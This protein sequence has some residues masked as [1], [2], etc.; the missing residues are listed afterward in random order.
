MSYFQK[1]SLQ[2]KVDFVKSLAVMLR[3]SIPLNEALTALAG[4]VKSKRFRE[5]LMRVKEKV[6]EGVPLG[7]A[8]AREGGAFDAITVN[9]LKAGEKSG[10]LEEN[11]SFLAA[12]LEH[13]NEMGKEIS[14]AMLYPKIVFS[15]TAL[16]GGWIGV[17]ILPKLVPFFRALRVELPFSTRFLLALSLFISKF[18]LLITVG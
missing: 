14:A 16:L 10:K 12:W 9:L 4:Q 13:K 11:L 2:E 17:L 1:I 3:S 15:A 5:V 6:E 8:F 7:E 18:W